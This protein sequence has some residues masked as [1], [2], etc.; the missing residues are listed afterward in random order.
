MSS[1]A[2]SEIPSHD[3]HGPQPATYYLVFAALIVLTVLTVGLSFLEL[4]VWHLA[5]GIAIGVI[6]ALL[7]VLFF[8]HV[9]YS[10]RLTWIMIIAGLFWT[11]ILIGGVVSDYLTRSW[12]IY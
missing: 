2:M 12:L 10:S 7:V 11:A 6:K 5:V 8:M 4:G 1:R 3:S 9:L